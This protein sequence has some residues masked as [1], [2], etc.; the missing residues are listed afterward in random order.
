MAYRSD[1][2]R[3]GR[4]GS[5]IGSWNA[6]KNPFRADSLILTDQRNEVRRLLPAIASPRWFRMPLNLRL[7]PRSPPFRRSWGQSGNRL[8]TMSTGGRYLPCQAN[9]AA[10]T[11]GTQQSNYPPASA[12]NKL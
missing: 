9:V 4:I 6:E 5:K 11:K 3:T 8:R 10:H 1:R 12:G 2:P 7:A